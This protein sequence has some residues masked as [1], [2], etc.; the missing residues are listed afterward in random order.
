L[1][2]CCAT[3]VCRIRFCA[4]SPHPFAIEGM[5][6]TQVSDRVLTLRR[7]DVHAFAVLSKLIG[8]EAEQVR[9]GVV[10]ENCLSLTTASA[11]HFCPT[12]AAKRPPES[13]IGASR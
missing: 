9:R 5:C 10:L 13:N 6:L 2:F 12:G 11:V 8:C 1:P 4:S 3:S 7:D